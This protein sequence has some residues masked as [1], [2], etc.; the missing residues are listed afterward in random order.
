MLTLLIRGFESHVFEHEITDNVGKNAELYKKYLCS[1]CR[2][3]SGLIFLRSS[4]I[5]IFL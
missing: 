4:P 5:H 2:R 3:V 1:N